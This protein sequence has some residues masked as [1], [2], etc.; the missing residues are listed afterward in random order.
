MSALL[1]LFPLDL[2][3][4]PGV[5]LP[6]HVFE[7][8]YQ[9]M[10]GEC[11]ELQRAFGVVRAVEDG[12]ARVGCTA[13]IV[14][15]STRYDDGRLDVVTQGVR[16]FELVHV[17]EERS[18]LQAEVV[19]L[20]DTPEQPTHAERERAVQFQIEILALAGELS[21][22][23]SI[24]N[25]LLSFELAGTLPLDLDFKQTLLSL[26]SEAQRVRALVQYCD[27]I[28]PKL[29]RVVRARKSSTG[30]GHAH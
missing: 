16:R 22:T 3:L 8:R 9:E 6:L 30:N 28:L 20:V 17:S 1:P 27:E 14:E 12:I 19:Y 29:R 24:D 5:Q 13:R 11:L 21:H 18:F 23:K 2:V 26:D 25:P 15:V 10:I 4:L 7:P